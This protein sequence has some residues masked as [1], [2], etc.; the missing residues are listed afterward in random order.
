V[1]GTPNGLVLYYSCEDAAGPTVSDSSGNGNHGT[2]AGG[3]AFQEAAELCQGIAFD[4]S[5]YVNVGTPASLSNLNKVTVEAWVK[6][7]Q[8]TSSYSSGIVAKTAGNGNLD[9]SLAIVSNGALYWASASNDGTYGYR[10]LITNAGA[11]ENGTWVHVAGTYDV[12]TNERRFYLN[13]V[14][15]V[16][17]SGSFG[18][19][20]AAPMDGT[21]PVHIGNY[22][23]DGGSNTDYL[24]GTVDDVR[25][26]NVVR[27]PAEICATAGGTFSGTS[28]TPAP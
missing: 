18:A 15:Q 14:A 3:V 4:G 26:W 24:D 6:R 21:G 10:A 8:A 1:A 2:A 22:V 19:D 7:D 27:T 20:V 16:A 28:C 17:S 13:G 23:W 12:T 11:I 25:I 5:G 9:F